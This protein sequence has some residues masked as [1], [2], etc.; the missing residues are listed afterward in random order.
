MT[1]QDIKPLLKALAS[2]ES[3]VKDLKVLLLLFATKLTTGNG[4]KV[5]TQKD[6]GR[7]LGLTD[8]QVRNLLNRRK[9]RKKR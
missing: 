6:L 4:S 3:E 5:V 1:A 8:R 9:K 2:V 7:A